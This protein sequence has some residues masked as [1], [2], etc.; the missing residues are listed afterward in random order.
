MLATCMEPVSVAPRD[1]RSLVLRRMNFAADLGAIANPL[2]MLLLLAWIHLSPATGLNTLDPNSAEA[3]DMAEYA[4]ITMGR[5]G[6]VVNRVVKVRLV[7]WNEVHNGKAYTLGYLTKP[8]ACTYPVHV[9]IERCL[10]DDTPP[11][12]D[13]LAV[14]TKPYED[15]VWTVDHYECGPPYRRDKY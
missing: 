15:D 3:Y 4:E 9:R 2:L 14:V 11:D 8:T 13:C 6:D 12:R 5:D 10:M 7:F 1:K